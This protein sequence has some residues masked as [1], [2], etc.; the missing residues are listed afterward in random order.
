MAPLMH[1]LVVDNASS[2]QTLE[3]VRDWPGVTV[4]ANRENRGFAAAANQGIRATD[5]ELLLLLNPDVKILTPVD[6]L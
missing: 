1:P 6:E 5:S 4:L 2:D 3:L